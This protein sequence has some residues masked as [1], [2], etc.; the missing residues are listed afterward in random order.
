[1]TDRLPAG[2]VRGRW[3]PSPYLLLAASALFW[4][5]NLVIGRAVAGEIPPIALNFYSPHPRASTPCTSM[6]T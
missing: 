5:G 1:M 4:G 6:P 2:T 3:A